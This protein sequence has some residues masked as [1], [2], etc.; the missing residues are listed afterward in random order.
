MGIYIYMYIYPLLIVPPGYGWNGHGGFRSPARP[1]WSP[2]TEEY[3]MAVDAEHG[4]REV[5]KNNV[6]ISAYDGLWPWIGNVHHMYPD[7]YSMFFPV[8]GWY[9]VIITY[10]DISWLITIHSKIG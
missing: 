9:K 10:C 5:L 3:Q 6:L 4:G 1:G 7:V 2:E 8:S